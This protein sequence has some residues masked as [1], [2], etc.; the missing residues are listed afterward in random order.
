MNEINAKP[1]DDGKAHNH[2]PRKSLGPKEHPE[3]VMEKGKGYNGGG[4]GQKVVHADMLLK[5]VQKTQRKGPIA[6]QKG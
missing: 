5:E 1:D 6:C 2:I 3:K 4:K